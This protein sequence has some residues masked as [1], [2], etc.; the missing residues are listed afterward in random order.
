MLSWCC[1]YECLE[2]EDR[3]ICKS[4]GAARLK[5]GEDIEITRDS[6]WRTKTGILIRIRDMDDQHLLN[7][8]RVLRAMSPIGTTFKTTPERRRRWLNAMSNEA[9]SR[10]L[11]LDEWTQNEPIHE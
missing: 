2:T 6:V 3:W 9:Y 10:E 11:E 5:T 7:T 1:Q 8:I 4:C